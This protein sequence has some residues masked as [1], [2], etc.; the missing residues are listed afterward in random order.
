MKQNKNI[1]TG[2]LLTAAIVVIVNVMSYSWFARFDFTKDKRYTLGAATLDILKDLKKPV[3][4]NAYFSENLPPA[5][6]QARADFKDILTEYAARSGNKVVFNFIDPNKNDTTERQAMQN[7]IN[8]V[9][10]NIREKDQMKQQKA[11]LGA[12]VKMGEKTDVIPFIQPGA[13]MEYSLSSSIKKLSID[14]KPTIGLLQGNGEATTGE[15]Q[16]VAQSLNVLYSFVALNLTDTTKIPTNFNTIAIVD[17]KDTFSVKQLNN[18]DEFL[19]RG[20]RL[21]ICYSGLKGDLQTASGRTVET[22]LTTWLAGKNVVMEHKFIIDAQCASVTVRQREGDL[23]FAN[24]VAFPFLPLIKNFSNHPIT[25]GL[26][27]VM[28]PF[29]TALKYTGDTNKVK[30]TVLATTSD[31]TGLKDAPLM[32]DI[33][34]Q[35]EQSEFALFNLPVAMALSGVDGNKDSRMVIVASSTFAVNGQGE[36]AQQLQGD[37]VDMFVN[38]IDWLSDDTGLIDLRSKEVK[39]VP[40]KDVSDS[41]KAFIKYFN[42]LLPLILVIVYGAIRMQL[43]RRLR[44]KRMNETYE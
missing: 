28:M 15:M 12:V 11:F 31:K 38:S 33:Q 44:L 42:F 22:G 14:K 25:K 10:V 6:S 1:T 39:S 43:K 5:I 24:N 8:P 32:F 9:M 20:G 7:G 29:A 40:L 21:L 4:I 18:L 13:A 16:Q 23:T 37:N 3:T 35:W 2:L 36:Q 30:C 27:T 41:T 17:P 19:G 26:G 34:H